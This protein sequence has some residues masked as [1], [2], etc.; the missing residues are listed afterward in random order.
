MISKYRDRIGSNR[1]RIVCGSTWSIGIQMHLCEKSRNAAFTLEFSA[2]TVFINPSTSCDRTQMLTATSNPLVVD[3][4]I[5][6]VIVVLKSRILPPCA[7]ILA[8]A[9]NPFRTSE[10]LP[11]VLII[12]TTE[13][14]W[15][16]GSEP[17][18]NARCSEESIDFSL[19][20]LQT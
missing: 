10:S 20:K 2:L 15:P 16:E 9:P 12:L 18:G 14:K 1:P 11:I 4:E 19:E 17:D 8:G 13:F 7:N 3:G 6:Q 5:E